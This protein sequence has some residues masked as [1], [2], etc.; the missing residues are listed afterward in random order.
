MTFSH[1]AFNK[2]IHLEKS[3]P[4]HNNVLLSDKL[5]IKP[6]NKFEHIVTSSLSVDFKVTD[7]NMDRLSKLQQDLQEKFE[8]TNNRVCILFIY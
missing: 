6:Q 1:L 8:Q 4:A 3:L 2:C 5:R 7:L